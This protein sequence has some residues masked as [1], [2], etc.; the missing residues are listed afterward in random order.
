[1]TEADILRREWIELLGAQPASDAAIH[2]GDLQT[3]G[4][5]RRIPVEVRS[6]G[7]RQ[8]LR[9]ALP[10][11]DSP[12]PVIVLPFYDTQVLFGE[13]SA[14]YPDP[15]AHP[16]RAFASEMLAAGLGVLAVP[17]WAETIAHAAPTVEL[18]AR[19]GPVAEDHLIRHPMVTGL[20]RSVSDLRLAVDA[21]S[22]IKQVDSHRIGMFGHSLGGKLSLF[23]SALDTRIAAAVTHEPGLGF[24]HSNWSDPWYFGARVPTDRDLDELLRLVAPRPILYVGGG[25][26]DGAHNEALARA[27][28]STDSRIEMLHHTKGHPL[29]EDLLR[30]MIRWLDRRLA[31]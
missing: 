8:V 3:D 4:A 12:C 9:L 22:D 17:W 15:N 23:A 2:V 10:I 29:P 5:I 11:G 20:G 19:Y 18:H 6:Y 30:Q 28:F 16:T 14:L 27:A 24:A 13:A 26:A 1:M 25:A 21:L 7:L 31:A